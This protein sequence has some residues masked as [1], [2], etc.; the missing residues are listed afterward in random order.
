MHWN[1]WSMPEHAHAGETLR[2]A[3]SP[4]AADEAGEADAITFSS[5]TWD[6]MTPANGSSMIGSRRLG[7][8][9]PTRLWYKL[10]WQIARP[11]HMLVAGLT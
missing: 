3:T 2:H 9:L 8:R 1:R 5:S 7:A 11:G 4:G 10:V 6:T